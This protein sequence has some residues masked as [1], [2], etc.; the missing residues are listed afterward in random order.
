MLQQ[1]KAQPVQVIILANQYNLKP[2]VATTTEEELGKIN[3]IVLGLLGFVVPINIAGILLLNILIH[4]LV[5]PAKQIHMHQNHQHLRQRLLY[6]LQQPDAVQIKQAIV[7][8][9]PMLVLA[10]NALPT[11]TVF[12]PLQEIAIQ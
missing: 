5:Q 6:L 4:G 7:S 10:R 3:L 9:D 2:V 11:H 8:I 1:A 12:H